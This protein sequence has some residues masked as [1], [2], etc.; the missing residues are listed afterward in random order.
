VQQ[1]PE[2]RLKFKDKDWKEIARYQVEMFFN[3]NDKDVKEDLQRIMKLYSS[4]VYD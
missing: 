1:I 4:D 3:P 2:I